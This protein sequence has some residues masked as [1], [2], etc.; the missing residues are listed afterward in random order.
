MAHFLAKDIVDHF[1][2]LI[3]PVVYLSMFYFFTN[4]GSTFFDNYIVLVCLVYCV[5]GMGYAFATFLNPG[6][7]QLVVIWVKY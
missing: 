4:P 7:A 3:K 5:T 2:T 1:N 6:P